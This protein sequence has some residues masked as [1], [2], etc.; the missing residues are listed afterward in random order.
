[1]ENEEKN[2]K[3]FLEKVRDFFKAFWNIVKKIWLPI[4][5]LI[6]AISI[7]KRKEQKKEIKEDKKEIKEDKKEIEKETKEVEKTEKELE[8]ENQQTQQI[9]EDCKDKQEEHN[10]ELEDFL[11]G[12]KKGKKK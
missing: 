3:T 9:V 5:M 2:E 12:L 6:T 8:K 11:P 7:A 1:M 4:T 10:K